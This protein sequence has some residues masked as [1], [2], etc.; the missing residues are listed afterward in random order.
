M[1][2]TVRGMGHPLG[3][4]DN[5]PVFSDVKRDTQVILSGREVGAGLIVKVLLL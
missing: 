5:G 1:S 4:L 3:T 2:T